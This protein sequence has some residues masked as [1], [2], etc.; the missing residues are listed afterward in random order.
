MSGKFRR[1]ICFVTIFH[2]QEVISV[3]NPEQKHLLEV[4]K[5]PAKFPVDVEPGPNGKET[6]VLINGLII[7]G[8]RFGFSLTDLVERENLHSSHARF[9]E[10][11]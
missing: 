11:T 1:P 8:K 2:P 10:L 4:E 6:W 9:V 7:D 5:Y 3:D